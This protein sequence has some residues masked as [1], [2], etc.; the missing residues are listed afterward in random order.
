MQRA[1]V[2]RSLGMHI[3]RSSHGTFFLSFPLFFS[4]ATRLTVSNE[5]QRVLHES[6]LCFSP[7]FFL[8]FY[9]HRH[10]RCRRRRHHRPHRRVTQGDQNWRKPIAANLADRPALLYATIES[11]ILR[12]VLRPNSYRICNGR[13]VTGVRFLPLRNVVLWNRHWS[14]NCNLR[15]TNAEIWLTSLL[16]ESYIRSFLRNCAKFFSFL[17]LTTVAFN[18]YSVLRPISSTMIQL[19]DNVNRIVVTSVTNNVRKLSRSN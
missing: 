2:I 3:A 13:L 8:S 5:S 7:V 17:F 19:L 15:I 6:L 1:K 11:S 14:T 18:Y 9:R 12:T 16:R 10:R 4:I